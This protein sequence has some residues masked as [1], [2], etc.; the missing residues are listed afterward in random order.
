MLN[1]VYKEISQMPH[2][3]KKEITKNKCKS[4]FRKNQR[5]KKKDQQNQSRLNQKKERIKKKDKKN[6]S[7]L[8]YKK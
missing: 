7:R 6:Q 5:I 8:Q 1:L 3:R 4:I 2:N